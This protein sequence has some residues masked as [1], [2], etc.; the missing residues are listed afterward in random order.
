MLD[1]LLWVHALLLIVAGILGLS[2]FIVAKKPDA[3][4][5]IDK[6]VPFQAFI[7]VGLLAVALINWLR[8]GIVNVFKLFSVWPLFGLAILG[9]IF[10]GIILGFFFGMPQIAKWLPG[11]SNA[12]QKAS[13]LSK[14]IAPFQMLFGIVCLASGL[15]L[16]LYGLKILTPSV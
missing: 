3:K 15:L 1:G 16:L 6:L 13:E 14:K 8:A 4:A 2:G 11:E 12:E 7:G 5:M 10:G 9:A